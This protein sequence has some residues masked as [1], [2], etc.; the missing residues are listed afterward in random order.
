M[1]RAVSAFI[2]D[3]VQRGLADV[4]VKGARPQGRLIGAIEQIGI[5]IEQPG[6]RLRVGGGGV[7]AIARCLRVA[8]VE[9][10]ASMRERFE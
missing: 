2:E 10:V 1:D 7:V 3:V 5:R 9:S 6:V 8:H 4:I